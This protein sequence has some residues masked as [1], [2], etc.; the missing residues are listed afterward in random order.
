MK[1]AVIIFSIFLYFAILPAYSVINTE[2]HT[3]LHNNT[4]ITPGLNYNNNIRTTPQINTVNHIIINTG[5]E[6]EIYTPQVHYQTRRIY[7]YKDFAGPRRFPAR[8][9]YTPSFCMPAS[10]FNYNYH[11]PFCNHYLPYGSN[12]YLSF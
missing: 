2:N 1:K 9:Y 11:N 10:G 5:N 3:E 4:Y 12:M 8:S 7:R 6:T